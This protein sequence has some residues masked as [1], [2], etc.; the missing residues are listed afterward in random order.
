MAA[1]LEWVRDH[2]DVNRDRKIDY[3]EGISSVKDFLNNVIT[4]EQL[5]AVQAAYNDQ[6]L[7]PTYGTSPPPS[8]VTLLWVRDHYDVNRDRK[9][10]FNEAIKSTQD[11]SNNLI[12]LLNGYKF[13]T[14][15]QNR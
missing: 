14:W 2:Y 8:T 12:T 9:I 13:Q 5:D 7:L 15:F 4:K 1:T 6:T 11:F 10:D 3:D